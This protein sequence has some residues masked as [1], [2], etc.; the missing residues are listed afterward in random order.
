MAYE[1]EW[2][3]RAIGEYENLL[4]YLQSEWGRDIAIR[5]SIEIDL[6]IIHIQNSP[7]H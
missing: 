1:L 7:E 2:S 4:L 5:V 3:E 6:K